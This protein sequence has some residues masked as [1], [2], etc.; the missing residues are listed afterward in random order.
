MRTHPQPDPNVERRP[1]GYALPY[2]DFMETAIRRR[3]QLVPAIHTALEQMRTTALSP[4][5]SLYI[6]WPEADGAY[7]FNDTYL[8]CNVMVVAPMTNPQDNTTQLATRAL[9]LPEGEWIDTALHRVI[10]APASGLNLTVT[11]TLWETP[12]FVPS[13]AVIPVAP[14]ATSVTAYGSATNVAIPSATG[15]LEQHWE[16]WAG[17]AMSGH[18][19][20]FEDASLSWINCSFAVA[21]NGAV[22]ISITQ[23][24][25]ATLSRVHQFDLKMALAATVIK[26]CDSG[27]KVIGSTF[28]GSLLQQS[29]RV[30]SGGEATACVT[31]SGSPLLPPEARS[32]FVGLRERG[33]ILKQAVDHALPKPNTGSTGLYNFT[34]AAVRIELAMTTADYPAA[35]AELMHFKAAAATS[36]A[37]LKT[38]LPTSSN[39]SA[40]AEAWLL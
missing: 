14:L 9:W 25:S 12:V 37:M 4:L 35:I 29:V 39:L 17:A 31:L 24:E 27:T 20:V 16:V 11:S 38:V 30:S 32:G 2:S 8:F 19:V 40:V 6:D 13:G 3:G 36:V 34:T 28:S 26:A 15:E 10:T 18:G 23:P 1:W 22:T 5:R 7:L 33:H 21:P